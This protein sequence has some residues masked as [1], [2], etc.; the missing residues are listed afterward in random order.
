M[1]ILVACEESRGRQ[2]LMVNNIPGTL[3]KLQN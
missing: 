2:T 3:Q 1:K